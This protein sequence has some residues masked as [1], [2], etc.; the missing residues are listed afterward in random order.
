MGWI[1]DW[2]TGRGDDEYDD[3][4]EYD[5]TGD[6]GVECPAFDCGCKVCAVL[7]QLCIHE[8]GH[9]VAHLALEIPFSHAFA[10]VSADGSSGNGSVVM[11]ETYSIEGD[12]LI[13]AI[14]STLSG[15]AAENLWF[16][17]AAMAD[18]DDESIEA[19][20]TG[21]AAHTIAD[22]DMADAEAE[23]AN[24]VDEWGDQLERL[25]RDLF[26]HGSLTYEDCLV[27]A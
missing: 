25:A 4:D 27:Y 18:G 11:G 22:L 24:I 21:P 9:I 26:E 1:W 19:Y 14:V 16:G 13:D 15:A 12:E 5:E 23:A 20:L 7:A 17:A 3:D 2:I 10:N 8:A 6:E